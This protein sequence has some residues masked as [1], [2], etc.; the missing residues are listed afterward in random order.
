M[1]IDKSLVPK[2]RLKRHR[3]VLT[4]AE[5]VTALEDQDKWHEDETSVFGLPKVRNI[6][7][8]RRKKGEKE[9]AAE[10]APAEGEAPGAEPA[11]EK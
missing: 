4:R 9:E 2:S 10:V 1:S 5:R 6:Q 8:A 3:N 7:A 11:E